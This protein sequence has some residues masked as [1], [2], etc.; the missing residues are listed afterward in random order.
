MR[1]NEVWLGFGLALLSL[2]AIGDFDRGH[3]AISLRLHHSLYFR[4]LTWFALII[5]PAQAISAYL[6]YS[7]GRRLFA[8]SSV[9][10]WIGIVMTISAIVK[11]PTDGAWCAFV[12]AILN[13]QTALGKRSDA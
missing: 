11:T 12:L 4:I 5:G 7:F 6:S 8:C 3:S 13:M 9:L 10:C 2:L 1:R